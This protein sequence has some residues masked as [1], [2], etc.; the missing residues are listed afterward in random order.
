MMLPSRLFPN[1]VSGGLRLPSATY[2]IYCKR[3]SAV[4]TRSG[5]RPGSSSRK[6]PGGDAAAAVDLDSLLGDTASMEKLRS[7]LFSNM[8]SQHNKTSTSPET[9]SMAAPST[10]RSRDRGPPGTASPSRER[11]SARSEAV[12]ATSEKQGLGVKGEIGS[13][14]VE[15]V[16]RSS[17][18]DRSRRSDSDRGRGGGGRGRGEG[19]DGRS[20]SFSGRRDS[21]RGS[22]GGYSARGGGTWTAPPPREFAYPSGGADAPLAILKMGKEFLFQGGSPM[23]YSGA[24]E[25]VLP[26]GEGSGFCV[27]FFLPS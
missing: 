8:A 13:R 5:H 7:S 19:A 15:T 24:I 1:Y 3:A 4:V 26:E 27:L 6:K 20:S 14:G 2:D 18:D 16:K 12:G 25:K 11:S 23:V 9:T 17:P 21:G 22:S 10:G